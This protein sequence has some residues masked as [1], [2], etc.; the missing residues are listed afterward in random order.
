MERRAKEN[1]KGTERMDFI[2]GGVTKRKKAH[3]SCRITTEKE[4]KMKRHTW[5]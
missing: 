5:R 1:S 4:G 3:L 2:Q